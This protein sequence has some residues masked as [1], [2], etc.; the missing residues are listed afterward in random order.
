MNNFLW[1][2][3]TYIYINKYLNIYYTKKKKKKKK[4]NLF[5]IEQAGIN[6][7]QMLLQQRQQILRTN[8]TV[9]IYKI[10]IISKFDYLLF[11][12]IINI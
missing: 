12:I 5:I 11:I 4:K 10:Y 9:N 7:L 8:D 6:T 3:Y 2:K 1:V